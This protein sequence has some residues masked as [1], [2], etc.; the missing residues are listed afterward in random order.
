MGNI[1]LTILKAQMQP[2]KSKLSPTTARA[3]LELKF[4]LC[5]L[6]W[7]L[8]QRQRLSQAGLESRHDKACSLP[9]GVCA[10]FGNLA[11]HQWATR[12][13]S[14]TQRCCRAHIQV[15]LTGQPIVIH[16]LWTLIDAFSQFFSFFSFFRE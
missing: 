7:R 4:K 6:E 10:T 2:K 8:R 14:A 16:S 11:R 9:L 12:M 15:N 5:L 13:R 1:I 3:R